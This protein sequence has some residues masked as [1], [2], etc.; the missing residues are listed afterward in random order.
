VAS[1]PPLGPAEEAV[2]EDGP[3]V[4]SDVALASPS[5]A[6]PSC[7]RVRRASSANQNGRRS[8]VF[9]C[10]TTLNPLPP[11]ATFPLRQFAWP[12]SHLG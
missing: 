5:S 3:V 2:C 11:A 4:W 1:W 10:Q 7:C 9:Q 12:V 6:S 8:R